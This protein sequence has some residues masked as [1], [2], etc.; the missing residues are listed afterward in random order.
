MKICCKI[1]ILV[2]NFGYGI[3]NPTMCLYR[4][5]IPDPYYYLYCF[6]KNSLLQIW[7]RIPN[8]CVKNDSKNVKPLYRSKKY[9]KVYY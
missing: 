5:F 3:I 2:N 9:L 6:I 7:L 4:V 8:S 1:E